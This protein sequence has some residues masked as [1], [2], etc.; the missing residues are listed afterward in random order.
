MRSSLCDIPDEIVRHILWYLPP[1]DTLLSFQLLSRRYHHI[2]NEPLLWRWYCQKSFRYWHPRHRFHEKLAALASSVDWKGLWITRKQINK[3]IAQLLNEVLRTKVGQMRNLGQICEMGY[4][5]K[6]YLLE[7]CHCDENAEDVLARRYY[8]HTALDSIH[9]GV[10]V[11]VW[12]RYQGQPLSYRGLDTALG[13]FDMFVLH[14]QPYDLDYVCDF[15][16]RDM[17]VPLYMSQTDR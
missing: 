6:D 17:C 13:A 4:D 11:E 10:A 16:T 9:R 3:R 8:A 12:S 14:D 2:A 5:A 15:L 1:E 7:Q